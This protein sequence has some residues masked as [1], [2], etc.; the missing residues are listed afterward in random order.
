VRGRARSTAVRT[1][2]ATIEAFERAGYRVAA[3]GDFE[4][5]LEADGA[6]PLQVRMVPDGRIFGG[7][8]ALEVGTA[9]PVLPATRGLTGRPRG[10]VK[11]RG[12]AFRWRRGDLDGSILAERLD[13][14]ERL[15]RSLPEVHFERI[16]VDP[17]GRAVIRHMGGSVVWMLFPP[18]VRPVPLVPEQIPA[19]ADAL[20][21]FAEAGRR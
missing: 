2:A 18:I 19:L 3:K 7:C 6:V 20:D 4:R 10:A 21:A 12:V 11:L 17:E 5:R 1:L 16:R 8:W 9:D 15:Q 13:A 14:D